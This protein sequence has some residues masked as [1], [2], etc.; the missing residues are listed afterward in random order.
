MKKKK[1]YVFMA[2][3]IIIAGIGIYSYKLYNKP[4]RDVQKTK[5]AYELQAIIIFNEFKTFEEKAAEKYVGEVII[6]EGSIMAILSNDS[7]ANILLKTH[8]DIFGVN[9][10]LL[11]DK[12]HQT[13]KIKK[14]QIVKIKGE[15]Q[16][17]IDDVIFNKCAIIE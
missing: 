11:P 8:D 15:C 2:I 12:L 3:L 14:G 5:P 17:I 9:C 10:A 6:V 4:H 13:K 16:G 7:T 1:V